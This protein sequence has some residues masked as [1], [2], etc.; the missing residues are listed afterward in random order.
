[1]D[2]KKISDK[3]PKRLSKLIEAAF[4]LDTER[5]SLE[6]KARELESE[7]RAIKDLLINQ[8][9]K[10]DLKEIKTRL[11]TARL[12]SKDIPIIDPDTGGWD[13]VYKYIVKHKAWELLQK[14]FGE[15]AC[16]ERWEAGEKIP[17]I[18]K[19]HKVEVKLGDAE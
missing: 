1:M 19:F 15:K 10:A 6:Y 12:S 2:W 9:D 11:G 3:D 18:Q 5:K 8:F 7:V 16:Q 4:T 13:A 14:R 17:G